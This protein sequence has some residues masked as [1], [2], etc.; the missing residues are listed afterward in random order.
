M[1]FTVNGLRRL[2]APKP[3]YLLKINVEREC[4]KVIERKNKN[5]AGK[6]NLKKGTIV[7]KQ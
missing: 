7:M 2:S 6:G 3:K 1:G 5:D 4:R